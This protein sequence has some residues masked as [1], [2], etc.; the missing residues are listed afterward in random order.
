MGRCVAGLTGYA[1]QLA[2]R[3]QEGQ[4]PRLRQLCVEMAEFWGLTDDLTHSGLREM[5]ERIGGDHDCAVSTARESG[6]APELDGQAKEDI[7]AGLDLYA[8]EMALHDDHGQW[9]AECRGLSAQL[10]AGWGMDAGECMN[11]AR[12]GALLEELRQDI[13]YGAGSDHPPPGGLLS[14]RPSSRSARSRN[15]SLTGRIGQPSRIPTLFCSCYQ[16]ILSLKICGHYS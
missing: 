9:I 1:A 5:A 10:R 15:P 2:A 3:D 4:V 16:T 12:Y 14:P 7:L 6:H 8:R 13:A 11:P